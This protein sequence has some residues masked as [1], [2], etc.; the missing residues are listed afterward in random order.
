MQSQVKG[1]SRHKLRMIMLGLE[2]S[3]DKWWFGLTAS[4]SKPAQAYL[5]ILNFQKTRNTLNG[6]S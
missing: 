6:G 2:D 4:K 5:L 3:Q 1:S